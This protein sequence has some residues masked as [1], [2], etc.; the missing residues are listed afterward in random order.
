M[1]ESAS[2]GSVP[3]ITEG[4][5][6]NET[7]GN[8]EICMWLTEKVGLPQYL[9]NMVQNGYDSLNMIKEIRNIS[10]LV[11]IGIEDGD[12]SDKIMKAILQIHHSTTPIGSEN[13]HHE[14]I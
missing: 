14:G 9:P 1:P 7:K 5:E 13:L 8:D 2:P 3:S 12:H 10:D 4:N 6:G 11:E